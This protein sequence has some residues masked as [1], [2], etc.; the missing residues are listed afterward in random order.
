MAYNGGMGQPNLGLYLVKHP[1]PLR[2]A[3]TRHAII[4][5]YETE[6]VKPRRKLCRRQEAR[7]LRKF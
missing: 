6:N 2:A 7:R 3:A 5:L 1:H 4:T